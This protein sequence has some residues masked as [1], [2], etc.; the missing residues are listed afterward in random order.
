MRG[1]RSR[2]NLR[3]GGRAGFSWRRNDRANPGPSR[4][5][6]PGPNNP[7]YHQWNNHHGDPRQWNHES[8]SEQDT[9][10]SEIYR[11]AYGFDDRSMPSRDIDDRSFQ[12]RRSEPP[13]WH[14]PR[15]DHHSIREVEKRNQQMMQQSPILESRRPPSP[16]VF[17]PGSPKQTNQS[18]S[19]SFISD[20]SPRA[21]FNQA[22]EEN[23]NWNAEKKVRKDLFNS[24]NEEPE[25]P[26]PPVPTQNGTIENS[27]NLVRTFDYSN[28]VQEPVQFAIQPPKKFIDYSRSNPLSDDNNRDESSRDGSKKNRKRSPRRNADRDRRTDRERSRSPR[29]KKKKSREKRSRDKSRSPSPKPKKS[30]DRKKE[31]KSKIIEDEDQELY[32]PESGNEDVLYIPTSNQEFSKMDIPQEYAD[33]STHM[34]QVLETM[35]ERQ[36]LEMHKKLNEMFKTYFDAQ[37]ANLDFE[38]EEVEQEEEEIPQQDEEPVDQEPDDDEDEEDIELNELRQAAMQS[39]NIDSSSESLSGSKSKK[40][41]AE[42]DGNIRFENFQ[43]FKEYKQ[44]MREKGLENESLIVSI[45]NTNAESSSILDN[46]MSILEKVDLEKKSENSKNDPKATPNLQMTVKLSNDQEQRQVLGPGSKAGLHAQH[47]S[48]DNPNTEKPHTD[49][50]SDKNENQ[51]KISEKAG[52]KWTDLVYR[53]PGKHWC[54]ITTRWMTSFEALLLHLH[55]DEYHSKLTIKDK[56]WKK[57][58]DTFTST[59]KER[60]AVRES[61][62]ETIDLSKGSEFIVPIQAFKCKLCEK[63]FRTEADVSAHFLGAAHNL[64]YEEFIKANKN[65]E[66][67]RLEKMQKSVQEKKREIENQRKLCNIQLRQKLSS[68]KRHKSPVSSYDQS[69]PT[70]KSTFSINYSQSELS[71]SEVKKPISFAA[72]AAKMQP[73]AAK[74]KST[75]VQQ[76]NQPA[77]VTIIKDSPPK[78][79]PP[80]EKRSPEKPPTEAQNKVPKKPRSAAIERILAM[81]KKKKKS[82]NCGGNNN[83]HS[84]SPRDTPSPPPSRSPDE[85]LDSPVSETI[86][87]T[88]GDVIKSPERNDVITSPV[89]NVPVL[90]PNSPIVDNTPTSEISPNYSP[91]PCDTNG[92]QQNVGDDVIKLT[93][94]KSGQEET[95]QEPNL[96]VSSPIHEPSDPNLPTNQSPT[97]DSHESS[98]AREISNIALNDTKSYEIENP[99]EISLSNQ[100]ACISVNSPVTHLP[101]QDSSSDSLPYD[102]A[103]KVDVIKSPDDDVIRDDPSHYSVDIDERVAQE[104]Q[105]AVKVT[106][107]EELNDQIGGNDREELNDQIF[108]KNP[109]AA[110]ELVGPDPNGS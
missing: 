64:K 2:G 37:T 21:N 61:L 19:P 11:R 59:L 86:Q 68:K 17:Y 70:K 15:Y 13:D 53:D 100:N 4:P 39:A 95:D 65:Y 96:E 106:S 55:S 18:E 84:L 38:D 107:L 97:R 110:A 63:I 9:N 54:Q 3:G 82:K 85:M 104:I 52:L 67:I 102:L 49:S 57:R 94:T 79:S 60:D 25:R 46:E 81:S 40:P 8:Y 75:E 42:K 30:K 92:E 16:R 23:R 50:K 41:L 91:N 58:L 5:A 43:Q 103:A 78:H 83:H 99:S 62:N 27:D 105:Q 71:A 10:E 1:H 80:T 66:F 93:E 35:M 36:R 87:E 45:P 44:K 14:P 22:G 77:D 74:L 76:K 20:Q 47:S 31:K 101:P 88:S 28:T 72:L 73:A 34:T 7:N 69:N 109:N 12:H 6:N 108:D 33:I 51:P 32:E 56:P 89:Q 26:K 90:L 29:S 24:T 98:P 48:S